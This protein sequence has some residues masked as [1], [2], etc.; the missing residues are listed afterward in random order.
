MI[1]N[2]LIKNQLTK[3]TCPSCGKSLETAKLVTLNELPFVYIAHAMCSKC[4]SGNIVTV[5]SLG[6]GVVATLSDLTSREISKFLNKQAIT[7]KH[8]INVHKLLKK[9]KLCNL[10]Q[11]KEQN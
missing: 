11:I 2:E 9:N 6:T 1:E 5:T 8:V 4:K 7:Y 10:L 3:A